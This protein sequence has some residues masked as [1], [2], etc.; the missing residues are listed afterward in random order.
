MAWRLSVFSMKTV[1]NGFEPGV[2]SKCI[3]KGV[4]IEW[5]ESR[6]EVEKSPVCAPR[7]GCFVRRVVGLRIEG[8]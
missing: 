1:R 4:P 3:L 7:C 8:V 5:S 2:R 6:I